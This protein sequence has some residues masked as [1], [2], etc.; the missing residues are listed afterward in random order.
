MTSND[1][2]RLYGATRR[3]VVLGGGALAAAA[4]AVGP[5]AAQTFE[6]IDIHAHIR[7]D[8]LSRY[9]PL[10]A[11]TA[12]GVAGRGTTVEQML[13]EMDAAGISKA[14][15]VQLSSFYGPDNSYVADSMAKAPKRLT[16]VCSIDILAPDAPAVL[17]GWLKRGVTGLRVYTGGTGESNTALLDDPRGFPVWEYCE[18]HKVPVCAQTTPDGLPKLVALLKRFPKAVVILDHGARPRLDA[19]PPF[20]EAQSLFDLAAYP[21]LSVKVTP[22]LNAQTRMGKSTPRTF[23]AALNEAFGARRI[24]FGSNLPMTEGPMTRIV[25]DMKA[26]LAELPAADQAMI[27]GGTAKR[28]YPALA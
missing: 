5:A 13:A 21:N 15:V 17:A 16:G 27:F 23:Y 25:A 14:A 9:P 2:A 12:R 6:I 22:P 4:M 20:A 11:V 26:C 8:D 24:A 3:D 1:G 7:S 10:A 28:L 19:G 18:A